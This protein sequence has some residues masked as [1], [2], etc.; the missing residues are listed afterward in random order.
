VTQLPPFPPYCSE[1]VIS[2]GWVKYGMTMR[3]LQMYTC[4]GMRERRKKKETKCAI[5][6]KKKKTLN[7]E[8][9][10]PF[11]KISMA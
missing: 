11:D 8:T 7:D 5:K 1:L 2:P 3:T 4:T 6:L 10:F 9:Y